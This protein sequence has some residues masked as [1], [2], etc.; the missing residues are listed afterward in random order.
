MYVLRLSLPSL[1]LSDV[2]TSLAAQ[3]SVPKSRTKDFEEE[4]YDG[5]VEGE[6]KLD[7]QSQGYDGFLTPGIGEEDVDMSG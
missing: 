5:A 6:R 2:L 7:T 1:F 3:P 4:D